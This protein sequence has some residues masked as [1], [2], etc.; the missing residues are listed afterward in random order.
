MFSAR[1]QAKMRALIKKS[2]RA[3]AFRSFA[4]SVA[5]VLL[6]ALMVAGIWLAFDGEARAEFF[7]WIRN[8]YEE[9]IVYNFFEK[10]ETK[11][12]P[13]IEAGWLPEGYAETMEDTGKESRYILYTNNEG[14]SIIFYYRFIYSDLASSV[15]KDRDIEYEEVSINDDFADFYHNIDG[16]DQNMLYWVDEEMN[17]ELSINAFLGKDIMIKIAENIRI[18]E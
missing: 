3:R 11:A 10:R 1:F 15:T 7:Q 8:E 14:K 5:A 4:R 18:I 2:R 13:E 16:D 17:M 12:L 9:R 6:V